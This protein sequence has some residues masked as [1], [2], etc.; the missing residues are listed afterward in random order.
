MAQNS[1][2]FGNTLA[3]RTLN[4]GGSIT[5]GG[6]PQLIMP[7]G[8]TR[9]FM[10]IQNTSAANLR[11]GIGPALATAS[12][13][14]G[15]VSSIAVANAG[16]GYTKPPQVRIVGGIGGGY[17]FPAPASEATMASAHAVLSGATI[18]SIVV[19]NGGS[20]YTSA[21]YVYLENDP[22]DPTGSYAPS[23]TA[24]AL[25]TPGGSWVWEC[26]TVTQ[27]AVSIYG[28]TTGQTFECWVVP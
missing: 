24:G 13:S 6:T 14:G 10:M 3:A 12:I 2:V 1:A 11:V 21:P 25:L 16:I 18:G 19:D 27:D 20:G 23:A 22:R 5:T 9:T 7:V 15:A 26:T 17:G 28:A 4:F 8:T